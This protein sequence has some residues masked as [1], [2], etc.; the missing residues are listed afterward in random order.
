VSAG[1]AGAIEIE[2]R[3]FG[4]TA[5]GKGPP[6]LLVNG[7]AATAADWDPAFLGQLAEGFEV[8]CP[9][10]RGFG[11]SELGEPGELSVEAMAADL[12]A[13]LDALEIE[14]V[15]VV[16]WSMGGFVAQ[17]L[18]LRAPGRVSALALLGADPGGKEAV[19]AE[20]A[21]WTALTDRSG[22]PREQASRLIAL[23]FP[24]ALAPRMDR[25]F[26]DIVATAQALL[27]TAALRAQEAA[28]EAWHATEQERP[29]QAPPTLVLHGERDVVIPAVNAGTLAD[30]WAASASS[31]P[32]PDTPS[33]PRSR[34]D[35][36]RSCAT[37][38]AEDRPVQSPREIL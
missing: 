4:W 36:R 38:S 2:G 9:D 31:S 21:V 29:Q 32:A 14:R 23:L 12:E 8:L 19:L 37:S 18:A 28:M 11:D 33:W 3:R 26:G 27:S 34:S 6:L 25:E 24:P 30:R 22:T 7:Y 10:N 15:P 13:L 20:P 16:G 5:A 17:R 35:W 1:D